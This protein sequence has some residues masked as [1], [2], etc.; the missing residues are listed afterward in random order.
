MKIS[1]FLTP[2]KR[3][4]GKAE[5]KSAS[6]KEGKS[7]SK[8]KESHLIDIIGCDCDSYFGIR[9]R[10]K[11][12]DLKVRT[13]ILIVSEY[14]DAESNRYKQSKIIPASQLEKMN[15]LVMSI[16][17]T[18]TEE[19]DPETASPTWIKEIVTSCMKSEPKA[20]KGETKPTFIDRMEEF[21]ATHDI[22][23]NS[24]ITYSPTVKKLKRFVAY[25]REVEGVTG[26]QLYVETITEDD[27]LCFQNYITHEYEY[28]K[29]RPDFYSQFEFGRPPKPLAKS[30]TT[31]MIRHLRTIQ[32]WCV[33]MG[34]TDNKSYEN[35]SNPDSTYGTPIYLTP[36]EV[37][38]IYK[39][40]LSDQ[41]ESIQL[42]RDQFI[43]HCMVG[44]RVGDLF[45]FTW[46][47]IRNGILQYVPH[48]TRIKVGAHIELPLNATSMEILNRYHCADGRL[49]PEHSVTKITYAYNKALKELFT[50]CGITRI[51]TVNDPKTN[52]SV[53]RHINEIASSHMARRTF[54]GTLY[55]KVLDPQLICSLTGHTKGSRSFT[56]YREIDEE[57]KQNLVN[58]IN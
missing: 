14:W 30:S 8:R 10:E 4:A 37:S 24:L 23:K 18:L 6:T 39:K 25:R 12:I 1:T 34:Y 20:K 57:I 58:L 15:T 11:Q 40:D 47:N 50:I 22:A 55:K 32:R 17:E 38:T 48:K 16:L 53:Q 42:C 49:F 56:R 27:Y 29:E 19:F 45:H 26:F 31:Y 13:D 21:L 2:I 3:K 44:C 41:P 51:V 54:I 33:R 36:E 52:L 5:S 28:Y 46:G 7:A 43:F 9:V 35:V